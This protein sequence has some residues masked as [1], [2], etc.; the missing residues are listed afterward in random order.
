MVR[1][2]VIGLVLI[3]I[4]CCL[5]QQRAAEAGSRTVN[6]TFNGTTVNCSG[7]VFDSGSITAN[8]E[9]WQGST[10]LISWPGSGNGFVQISE[11]YTV[12]SGVTYTLKMNGTI[13]GVSFPEASVTKTCP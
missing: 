8:L 13:N 4:C 9:L 10:K 5:C 6:L 1:K 12:V 3:G 2:I 7:T 11:T